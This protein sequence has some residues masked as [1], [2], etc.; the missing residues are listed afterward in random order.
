MNLN[1]NIVLGGTMNLFIGNKISKSAQLM[2]ILSVL[3]FSGCKSITG[4]LDVNQ[5]FTAISEKNTS[6][7]G[8]DRTPW[9][10]PCDETDGVVKINE[11]MY[12]AK[13]NFLS[14]SKLEIE[15]KQNNSSKKFQVKIPSS[16]SIPKNG[17]FQIPSSKSGQTFDLTGAV[18][19]VE[20]KSKN[21]Q[22]WE[23]CRVIR[24]EVIC[25][26]VGNPP[27]MECS[28]VRRETWGERRV[29][30]Y[31]LDTTQNVRVNLL[32]KSSENL[33]AQFDGTEKY[34]EKVITRA[35]YCN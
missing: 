1:S 21:F 5:T 9:S 3:I 19:T 30:F 11:G 15:V 16:V 7:C 12:D 17:E 8:P 10:P 13:I 29:D 26:P 23:R 18:K 27:A 22:D 2:L 32:E 35:G 20:V 28:P 34:R 31:Y 4:Q 6:G 33:L 24:E 25:R 14:K